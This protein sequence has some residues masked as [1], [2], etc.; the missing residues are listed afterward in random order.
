MGLKDEH[1]VCR[2]TV[3]EQV[4]GGQGRAV[5]AGDV[6]TDIAGKPIKDGREL[7]T[8]VAGLPVGKP[9]DMT[10]LRDS[11]PQGVTVTIEEQP[12]EFGDGSRGGAPA[13]ESKSGS[14]GVD[15]VGVSVADLTPQMAEELGFK[16]SVKGA[17]ITNVEAGSVAS[18]AG[19]RQGMVISKV[20]NQPVATANAAREALEKGSLRRGIL[21][22]VQSPESG[23]Q[24]C[25]ATAAR[26]GEQVVLAREFHKPDAQARDIPRLR[27]GL[28]ESRA[29]YA[30]KEVPHKPDCA[31]EG[32]LACASGL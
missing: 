6:I 8:I 18:E 10:V 9:A 27:V 11:K 21:L 12:K 28:V 30:G 2:R 5:K 20:D 3:F 24:L 14:V 15:K 25:A 13:P 16:G 23:A 31:S 19:L 17:A 7:Q 1:G 22:Q 32:T 26:D 29:H 4:A